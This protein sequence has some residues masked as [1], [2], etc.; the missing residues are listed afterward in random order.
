LQDN[1]A[2]EDGM[3]ERAT[4]DHP[5]ETA[6]DSPPV[7][8]I[9][10]TAGF[11]A[12]LAFVAF[13]GIDLLAARLF[14]TGGNEFISRPHG[15]LEGLRFAMNQVFLLALLGVAGGVLASAFSGLRLMGFDF[16]RWSFLA[17]ALLLGPFITVNGV[18]KSEWGR[19]RP[20]HIQE[21]GGDKS[22]SPA[23][24]RS[25]QCDANCSFVSGETAAIFTMA[26]APALLLTGRRRRETMGAALAAGAFMGLLRMAAGGHFLSDVVFAII[27]SAL[28]T[29]FTYW[30]VFEKRP[31]WF[32]NEGPIRSALLNLGRRA[33]SQGPEVFQKLRAR[34]RGAPKD[35]TDQRPD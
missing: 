22:F 7:V 26:F 9:A 1:S 5:A 14:Y 31:Q 20:H 3:T 18:F 34:A 12:S 29:R 21:F 23:L 15:L 27:F 8:F 13:P 4:L 30:L 6:S 28:T 10:M 33:R 25:N 16:A 24:A 11:A 35:Q 19:A 17:L 2:K 32:E